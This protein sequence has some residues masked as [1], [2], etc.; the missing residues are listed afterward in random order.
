VPPADLAFLSAN[1]AA[2]QTAGAQ[3]TALGAVPAADLAFLGKYGTGLKDPKVVGALTVL[4][5]QG[6]I[7]QQAQKDAPGQW[8]R[9]WWICL[10]GQLLFLPFIWLMT[11]RWSPAK[12]RADAAVHDEAV[13]RELAALTSDES[14][15]EPAV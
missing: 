2:V 13:S 14:G 4:Q 8:Q 7:V 11:G 6:P 15:S 10:A 3:L 9:W 12:A 1:G 5:K